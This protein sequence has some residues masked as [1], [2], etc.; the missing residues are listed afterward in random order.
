M[1]KLEFGTLASHARY[2]TY[3]SWPR[4]G[5]RPNLRLSTSAKWEQITPALLALQDYYEGQMQSYT[6]GAFKL[7]CMILKWGIG[8]TRQEREQKGR[9]WIFSGRFRL[10][11]LIPISEK[12]HSNEWRS[13]Q[14][15]SVFAE[16]YQSKSCHSVKSFRCSNWLLGYIHPLPFPDQDF[17]L[18]I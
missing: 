16:T 5:N 12:S 15:K 13:S 4:A 10:P 8:N 6:K 2:V 14:S 17:P 11:L 9:G 1:W 18:K 3:T 7:S